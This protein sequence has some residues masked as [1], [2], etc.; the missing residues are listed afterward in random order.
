[1]T[2]SSSSRKT[3][4]QP[5]PPS[6]ISNKFTCCV[7]CGA[8]SHDRL[9]K[10]YGSS[11]HS[12]NIRL[13]HC[14]VCD[15]HLDKYLEYDPVLIVIDLILHKIEVYRHLLFNS[16]VFLPRAHSIIS[17]ASIVFFIMVCFD[18]YIKWHTSK[19]GGTL[20]VVPELERCLQ[21]CPTDETIAGLDGS[22]G[23]RGGFT[24]GVLGGGISLGGLSLGVG[25]GLPPRAM[26][27]TNL[28]NNPDKIVSSKESINIIPM[29]SS[30]PSLSSSPL[31]Y[32]GRCFNTST[33]DA[34]IERFVDGIR[35]SD[36]LLRCISFFSLALIENILYIAGIVLSIRLWESICPLNTKTDDDRRTTTAT[37][38]NNNRRRRTSSKNKIKQMNNNNT[39]A[40]INIMNNNTNNNKESEKSLSNISNEETQ[41]N[42]TRNAGTSASVD[43]ILFG[44]DKEGEKKVVKKRSRTE[45][46][47]G[48]ESSVSTT[49]IVCAIILSSW[50]KALLLLL[51]VWE[52]SN[53]MIHVIN[54]VV[55]ASNFTAVH[56]LLSIGKWPPRP[57][58]LFLVLFPFSMRTIIQMALA[59]TFG[60]SVVY[61]TAYTPW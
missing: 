30:S 60:L 32:A 1:M 55:V 57:V 52:Y 13:T 33:E 41:R 42:N 15:A 11:S 19:Y 2:T 21:L 12:G 27:N 53:D 8:R 48:L 45:S 4:I 3:L 25:K 46:M 44:N 5:P 26:I 20:F 24:K 54:F 50:G 36:F 28:L 58:S 18:A 16:S 29:V 10:E 38:N 14:Q 56:S 51:M 49:M 43:S 31:P 59:H 40:T 9:Y 35:D 23:T 22:G 47:D 6:S 7:E 39:N 34:I 61:S 37:N 17:N